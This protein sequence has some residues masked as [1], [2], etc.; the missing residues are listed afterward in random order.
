MKHF[1]PYCFT[2]LPKKNTTFQCQSNTTQCSHVIDEVLHKKWGTDTPQGKI[3]EHSSGILT[4]KGATCPDCNSSTSI[5]CCPNCHKDISLLC[6]HKTHHH[7]FLVS[8]NPTEAAFLIQDIESSVTQHISHHK[9]FVI[10]FQQNHKSPF[11][12]AFKSSKDTHLF[13]FHTLN[14]EDLASPAIASQKDNV[15]A[16]LVVLPYNPPSSLTPALHYMSSKLSNSKALGLI[17]QNTTSL[18][19]YIPPNHIFFR[20][21]PLTAQGALPEAAHTTASA[22]HDLI[23]IAWGSHSTRYI[24]THFTQNRF[25]IYTPH[26]NNDTPT[27]RGWRVDD[28][29]YWIFDLA[30]F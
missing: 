10:T 25:F 8:N 9:N 22:T 24:D 3:F 23:T 18:L 13:I 12:F 29:V 4:S 30:R 20:P 5:M 16:N 15:L 1:C 2:N 21:T 26:I 14:W 19:S 17:I 28:I 27:P 11:I 7:I 6:Q